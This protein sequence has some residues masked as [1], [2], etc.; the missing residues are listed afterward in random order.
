MTIEEIKYYPF[1]YF[2]CPFCKDNG[3][4]S[5]KC[6]YGDSFIGYITKIECEKC[7]CTQGWHW[8]K[9]PLESQ[10]SA[11]LDWNKRE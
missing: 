4:I 3:K 7:H 6:E 8:G 1:I 9:T 2:E 11:N 10:S 5:V